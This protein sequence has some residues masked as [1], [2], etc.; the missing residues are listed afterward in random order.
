MSVENGISQNGS[1]SDMSNTGLII[2]NPRGRCRTVC[3]CRSTWT[4]MRR[5]QWM[6]GFWMR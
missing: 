3:I 5:R 2:S 6:P 4:T 1:G